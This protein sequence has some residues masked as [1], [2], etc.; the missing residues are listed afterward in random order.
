MDGGRR[1]VI[2]W[3]AVRDGTEE[4]TEQLAFYENL[5]RRL[6]SKR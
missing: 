6:A 5:S 3:G 4:S 1:I 2:L